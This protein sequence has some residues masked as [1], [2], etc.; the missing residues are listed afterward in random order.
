MNISLRQ[1]EAFL[2]VSQ[3]EGFTRAAERLHLTQSAVSLLVRELENQLSV[4]L[5]DRT[6][7]AV[8]LTDAGRELYPFA[9]KAI[10]D[11]QAGIDNT[12]DLLAKKKGRVVL[13]APPLLASHLLPP[14]IARFGESYPGV[15]VSLRDLLADE[16]VARVASGEVDFGIGTFHRLE[17]DLEIQTL[18]RDSLILVAPRKHALARKRKLRWRDLEATPLIALDRHSGLRHLVDRTLEAAGSDPRPAYEV[19]FITTAI[20]MVEAGLGIAVLPSYSLLSTRHF[21]VET[22]LLEEPVVEREIALVSRAGRSLSPAAESFAEF[23]RNHVRES[24]GA[25][26]LRRSPRK[27]TMAG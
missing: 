2:A 10:A 6:T 13:G 5:F 25:T 7:R 11:L 3:L 24:L 19:S 14:V 27:T 9:E 8:G 20:G 18:A 26:P 1:L 17:E 16:I 15:A 12:R 23:A 4:R 22:R 21:R